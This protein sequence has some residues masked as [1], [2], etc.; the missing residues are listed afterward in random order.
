MLQ[1]KW[2]ALAPGPLPSKVSRPQLQ[3]ITR[4]T[5][6]AAASPSAPAKYKS[7]GR[8]VTYD[9]KLTRDGRRSQKGAGPIR[10]KQLVSK[11]SEDDTPTDAARPRTK[12]A[13]LKKGQRVTGVV[14]TVTAEG[15]IVNVRAEQ[16]ALLHESQLTPAFPLKSWKRG[17][18][19]VANIFY[20]N[21][22][23][24]K[25]TLK[26]VRSIKR[27]GIQEIL[28]IHCLMCAYR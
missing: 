25:L 24:L 27:K 26:E 3:W 10:R 18:K 14:R 21:P 22:S 13:D 9:G 4:A 16:D 12:L 7:D 11:T 19:V 23:T 8:R 6:E 2:G 28:P 15:V 5:D 17:D 1:T 20:V